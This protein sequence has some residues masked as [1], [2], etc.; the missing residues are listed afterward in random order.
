MATV[1]GVMAV[2]V[3]TNGT[4]MTTAYTGGM[5]EASVNPIDFP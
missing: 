1:C 2:T 5:A 4:E 3:M